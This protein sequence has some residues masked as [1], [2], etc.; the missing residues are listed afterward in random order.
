M[1]E[2]DPS[3]NPVCAHC[4]S[5]AMIPDAFLVA[6]GYGG[7]TIQVGIHTR[8]DA[9]MRKQPVLSDTD[10]SVCGECGTVRLQAE[11]PLALWEGH[12][13]RISRRG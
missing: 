10:V 13:E 6:K 11:D 1:P 3:I 12:L 5:D 9:M 4:G 7:L 8:P 2:R